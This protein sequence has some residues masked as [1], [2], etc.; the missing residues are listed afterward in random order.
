VR[1]RLAH[2]AANSAAHVPRRNLALER[3]ANDERENQGGGHTVLC[4]VTPTCSDPTEQRSR[5][6]ECSI[7]WTRCSPACHPH[8]ERARLDS[9]R[10]TIVQPAIW[11]VHTEVITRYVRREVPSL[12][13]TV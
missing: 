2:Y 3:A 6:L 12:K 8:G 5:K 7:G 11:R 9:W 13:L 4:V 10:C 1:K